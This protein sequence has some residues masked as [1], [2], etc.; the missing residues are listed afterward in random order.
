MASGPV[1]CTVFWS[2]SLAK[3]ARDRQG[4]KQCVEADTLPKWAKHVRTFGWT[5]NVQVQGGS[6]ITHCYI[7]VLFSGH[8][9]DFHPFLLHVR[10]Q[11]SPD[12]SPMWRITTNEEWK[13]GR[14]T[15]PSRKPSRYDD[16]EKPYH[17]EVRMKLWLSRINFNVWTIERRCWPKAT[18]QDS[19]LGFLNHPYF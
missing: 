13:V 10:G 11:S 18:F 16:R 4:G 19:F 14:M 9:F 5:T 3:D 2:W 7:L 17:F 6:E 1:S 12:A 15:K 8:K